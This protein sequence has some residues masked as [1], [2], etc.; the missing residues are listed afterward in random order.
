IWDVAS[1]RMQRSLPK[2]MSG[3]LAFTPD[4]RRVLAVPFGIGKTALQALDVATGSLAGG[5]ELEDRT[6]FMPASGDR[7]LCVPAD[8]KKVLMLTWKNGRTGDESVLTVWDRASR[9]CLV[10]K[11][12]P[13]A[14]DSVLTSVGESVLAFDSRAGAL[15]LLALDTGKP[16]WQFQA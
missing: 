3:H 1:A 2:G 12:V 4:G 9:A 11:R 8:E 15:R 6:E 7:E 13:W 14:E 10:H 16:R 5:F